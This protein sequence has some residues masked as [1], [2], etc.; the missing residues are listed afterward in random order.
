MKEQDAGGL[1]RAKLAVVLPLGLAQT[2]GW[3]SSY[4]LPAIL[5]EPIGRS[6]GE[7]ASVVFAAF[8]G[9]LLVSAAIA[10]RA[11]RF[12]DKI[13]G[14]TV[15]VLS[16]LFFA[17]GL[18]VLAASSSWPLLCLAW[19][20]IGIGMGMGLYDAAFATLTAIYGLG[21]RTPIAGVTLMGGFASTVGWPLT[22]WALA[23]FGWREACLGWALAHLLLGL[24]LNASLRAPKRNPVPRTHAHDPA[25]RIKI[26]RTM[27]L[28]S[29][30]FGA[31]WTISTAMAS[32]LPRVL[33]AAGATQ[34]QALLAG[35]LI[36]P[37]Q[38]AARLLDLLLLRRAH[39][40]LPARA[41]ALFH[42]FGVAL[43][44]SGTAAF[45]AFALLHG[46]G[47]G[48]L[49]IALGAVPLAIYGPLNY[50]HRLGVLGAPSRVAQAS[51]P[52]LFG[53]LIG[54]FGAGALLFSAALGLA[55]FAA[56]CMVDRTAGL[57]SDLQS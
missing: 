30:A 6:I 21:A 45:P 17:S 16:S 3:A 2:L 34:G 39:P 43:I 32:H 47:N 7:P 38:V 36:G 55:A 56:L 1:P 18:A 13:G 19:L 5:A 11:G 52:L 48:I 15:L 22:A 44:A 27:W 53:L 24:P 9:A 4:Y 31:G 57:K 35:A 20:L 49:T 14:R 54:R 12:I 23:N 8:S 50:G 25:P 51:A 37:A 42:P 28:L 29:F 40:L 33:E 46:A 10:P 41:A 26:E